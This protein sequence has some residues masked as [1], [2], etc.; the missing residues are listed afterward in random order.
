MAV[1]GYTTIASGIRGGSAINFDGS[2]NGLWA[3]TTRNKAVHKRQRSWILSGNFQANNF[4]FMQL[5]GSTYVN[6]MP[7]GIADVSILSYHVHLWHSQPIFAATSSEALPSLNQPRPEWHV[8]FS[9]T[10]SR[11]PLP[12]ALTQVSQPCDEASGVSSGIS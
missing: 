7:K 11:L 12:D 2:G 10:E 1:H 9:T 4:A 5:R 3:V 8:N 6:S